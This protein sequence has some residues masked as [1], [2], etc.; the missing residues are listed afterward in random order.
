MPLP[1][2]SEILY[3]DTLTPA[4]LERSY[5]GS[6]HPDIL[7]DSE[8]FS[9]VPD[10]AFDFVVANHVLEHVTSPIRALEEWHRILRPGGLLLMAIP[11]Q[12]FTFD[13]RRARTTLAHLIADRQ[14]NRPVDELNRCHLLEWAEHVERLIPGTPAFDGWIAAQTAN[15]FSVHNHVWV[16]QDLFDVLGWMN[17]QTNAHFVVEQWRNSSLLRGE[18]IL[19]LRAQAATPGRADGPD[20]IDAGRRI[21]ALQHPLLQLAALVTRS[22]ST[23]RRHFQPRP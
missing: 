4:Q 10:G 19:L 5:P 11:D 16:A 3:S 9:T 21:A 15:G 23:A 12:R 14:S 13:H 20:R 18:F 8:T 6:R 17:R 22:V 7:S 1:R 2:A